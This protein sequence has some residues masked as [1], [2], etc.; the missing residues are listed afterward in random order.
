[1]LASPNPVATTAMPK[2]VRSPLDPSQIQYSSK[3][4]QQAVADIVEQLTLD[5]STLKGIKDHFVQ[6]M[7]KGLAKDGETIAM[8]PSYVLDRLNGTEIGSYL[9]LDVGGTYIRVVSVNLLGHGQVV[10]QH[11]K[12][13]ID[14]ELKTSEAKLLFVDE[15]AIVV[16]LETE[17]ELGFTFSFPVKQ[18][19]ID[20]GT[21]ITWTKGFSCPHMVGK[22]PAAFLQDAFH[23]KNIP[24]RVAALLN[25]TVGTLLAYEYHHPSTVIG[26]GLGTGCNGAYLERVERI[27][28]WKRDPSDPQGEEVIV[29]MEFGAFDSERQVLPV[30]MFDNKVDRKSMN[31]GKQIF[32]KMIAGMYLGEITRNVLLH[33]ADRRLLF[34]D[35]SV[36]WEMNRVWAF[37]T[38]Y[39]STIEADNSPSLKATQMVLE[40]TLG[41]GSELD[42]GRQRV[43]SSMATT[44]VD[45]EIVKMVVQ[46]VGQRAARLAAAALAGILEHTMGVTWQEDTG[47]SIGV[48]GS[49][50]RYY[51]SF[52]S[53]ILD[54]LDAI[55][56]LEPKMKGLCRGESGEAKIRMGLNTEG[57]GAGAALCALM[58]GRQKVM[59]V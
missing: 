19:G 5:A 33:L 38:A 16:P 2:P 45:R 37:D 24:V 54:G 12:Y 6:E 20:S 46:L 55:F 47:A 57:G 40:S 14:E 29:N 22:D 56:G 31:T 13:K 43:D 10:S 58:A 39:M 41:F 4:Q 36:Q 8:V 51:P 9:T 30:T 15:H 44:L 28:K 23:R 59:E 50:Y 17:L 26:L 11:K 52:R 53:D 32:E 1:M 25:D 42:A 27:P 48:D 35:C 34:S 49:L 21:L 3:K 18:T 7:R